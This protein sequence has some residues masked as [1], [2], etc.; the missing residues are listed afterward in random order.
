MV[1][2]SR[3]LRYRETHR[4]TQTSHTILSTSYM[5]SPQ[6]QM[7]RHSSQ[8]ELY[9]LYLLHGDG[10]TRKRQVEDLFRE[11][12]SSDRRRGERRERN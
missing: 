5:P 10:Q 8:E 6:R 3:E 11:E 12:M 1:G 2:G 9:I 4:D 7:R